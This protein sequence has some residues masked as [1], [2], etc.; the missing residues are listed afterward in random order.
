MRVLCAKGASIDGSGGTDE[1]GLL[2]G[3]VRDSGCRLTGVG[4]WCAGELLR[5]RRALAS[6]DARAITTVIY[7]G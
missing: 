4:E 5:V 7:L 2:F 1:E 3:G 6:G